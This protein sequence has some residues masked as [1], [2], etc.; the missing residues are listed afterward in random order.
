MH[1]I[2][3]GEG[4]EGGTTRAR[5][6]GGA[7]TV[8]GVGAVC[9]VEQPKRPAAQSVGRRSRAR[10]WRPQQ[11]R[12]CQDGKSRTAGAAHM[13]TAK[14]LTRVRGMTRRC[15]ALAMRNAHDAVDNA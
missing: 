10:I 9:I 3:Y 5:R 1:A 15:R 12:A 7:P 14:I 13:G 2:A 11:Q 4:F 8:V 6:G